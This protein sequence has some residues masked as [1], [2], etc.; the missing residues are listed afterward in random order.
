MNDDVKKIIANVIYGT[1]C[2]VGP[3]N[4]PLGT[5]VRFAEQDGFLIWRSQSSSEHSRNIE[6][7]SQVAITLYDSSQ[8]IPGGVYIESYAEKLIGDEQIEALAVYAAKFE[9]P[10]KLGN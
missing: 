9:D 4:Q 2:T 6:I 1:L 10:N 3:N 7:N 5:I 8:A